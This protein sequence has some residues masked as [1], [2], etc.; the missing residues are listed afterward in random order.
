MS[1]ALLCDSHGLNGR[2]ESPRFITHKAFGSS[3]R[4]GVRII[5]A[6]TGLIARLGLQ[7]TVFPEVGKVTHL[8]TGY[9]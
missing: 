5:G 8:K 9:L 4:L 2:T 1:V 7:L 3:H 6:S